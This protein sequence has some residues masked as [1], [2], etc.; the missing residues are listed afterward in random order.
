MTAED[1]TGFGKKG[2]KPRGMRWIDALR[3][4]NAH[5]KSV[6]TAHVWATPRKGTAEHAEVKAIMD[7]HKPDVVA[8]RNEARRV[9]SIEQLKKATAHMKPGVSYA[10]TMEEKFNKQIEEMKRVNH[11]NE[12]HWTIRRLRIAIKRYPEAKSLREASDELDDE[13]YEERQLPDDRTMEQ[14][15]AARAATNARMAADAARMAAN[16]AA[17]AA[18]EKSLI[19]VV[20]VDNL[21]SPAPA[22][23]AA[24]KP[25]AAKK[26][27]TEAAA[28]PA[29][30]APPAPA[31]PPAPRG[32]TA[33]DIPEDVVKSYILPFT[34]G[35]EFN[36]GKVFFEAGSYFRRRAIGVLV[37]LKQI[38]EGENEKTLYGAREGDFPPAMLQT[39]GVKTTGRAQSMDDPFWFVREMAVASGEYVLEAPSKEQ[40]RILRNGFPDWMTIDAYRRKGTMGNKSGIVIITKVEST[41]LNLRT[42]AGKAEILKRQDEVSAIAMGYLKRIYAKDYTAFFKALEDKGV[43]KKEEVLAKKAEARGTYDFAK[44]EAKATFEPTDNFL[45]IMRAFFGPAHEEQAQAENHRL[46]GKA[47]G[48][49]AKFWIPRGKNLQIAWS[50]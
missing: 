40:L 46:M 36:L 34:K 24:P 43:K 20:R 37:I 25:S 21:P 45:H 3:H 50:S 14:S 30:P 18:R 31:A 48:R 44:T 47:A 49:R 16:A 9:T 39:Y 17:A 10:K 26:P 42:K 41:G 12:S 7:Y 5:H 8:A 11:Y 19:P 13:A 29:P 22:A 4:W 15:K 35:K 23:I 27:K 32:A 1:F 38:A 33:S 28:P 6:N 2:A